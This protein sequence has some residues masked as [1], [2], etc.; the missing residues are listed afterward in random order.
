[1]LA[2][3]L[4]ECNSFF[5][6]NHY[7]LCLKDTMQKDVIFSDQRVFYLFFILKAKD[8]FF[9][10]VMI[11]EEINIAKTMLSFSFRI[12]KGAGFLKTIGYLQ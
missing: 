3:F 5:L 11:F 8:L 10:L 9:C 2:I 12:V 4:F 6:F 1:M 7:M